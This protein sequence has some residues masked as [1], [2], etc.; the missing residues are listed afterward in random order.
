MPHGLPDDHDNRSAGDR[1]RRGDLAVLLTAIFGLGAGLLLFAPQADAKPKFMSEF[2]EAYPT[3]AGTNLDTCLLCHTDPA[4]PS[5]D[6]LNNYGRDFEDGDIG[7]KDFLAP[8]LVN[9]DSDGDGVPNGQEILQL[10]LPGDPS[11]S[12]PPTTTTTL[13]GTP[14]DGQ[15]LFAARCAACH[16]P[17]GGNLS[18]T[19]LARSTFI[20][21]TLNGQGGMPA[22]SGLSEAEVGA[23]WDYLTGVAPTTTTSTLPGATTTTTAPAA[24]AAVWAGHCAACHGANGGNLVPTSATRSR[25]VSIVTNGT[26][27][28]PSFTQLGSVQI[29]NVVDYLLSFGPPTTTTTLPGATTTTTIARSGSVVYAASCAL[30]HGTGGG[31]LQGHT[32]SQMQ[33]ATI[34]D[35]GRGSMPGF[36]GNLSSAEITNVARYVASLGTG[37][38]VTTT[39]TP[40]GS[41]VA[42]STL[43][44]QSCSGC[45]GLHGEGGGG[46]PV[47]GTALNRSQVLALIDA[48]ANGMPGF[49]SQLSAAEIAAVAD[50]ILAMNGSS[51]A[52]GSSGDEAE[53]GQP[54]EAAS[55]PE[56]AQG[57][58]LYGQFCAGC[59][60]ADG[61]GGFGG[62]LT[63]LEM[64]AAGLKQIIR[65]G[66]SSMPA[67]AG[68]MSD[69]ELDALV[70]FTASLGAEGIA[71]PFTGFGDREGLQRAG[72]LEDPAEGGGVPGLVMLLGGLGVLGG[73]GAAFLRFR[74][75]RHPVG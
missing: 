32:L 72:D 29:G 58:S 3:A 65:H 1:R 19:N 8:N 30:C 28:M 52:G 44:M 20:S 27:S 7:D 33:I 60:G 6:N 2:A 26:G 51:G 15:A 23:I 42:G 25:L 37:A 69:S 39:T 53:T 46:G 18:G 40:P 48:G 73:G 10:S 4:R 43:Y 70:A 68:Q 11:S 12:A 61:E 36:S 66:T 71:D 67:F 34:I 38:G 56:L 59:H 54:L 5:E 62:P 21:I 63:G 49:G 22:Q 74:P 50:H 57:H 41:P 14:P 75:A 16:G 24:G 64:S 9:R 35:N 17:D 47:A 13:P 45:H 31:N 55:S